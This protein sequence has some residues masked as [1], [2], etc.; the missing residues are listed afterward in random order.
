MAV[1]KKKRPSPYE[2]L[3]VMS[4]ATD[5]EIRAAYRNRAKVL[6]PDAG[7]GADEFAFL[8]ECLALLLDPE[9]R[10]RFDATGI[11][12]EIDPKIAQKR[13]VALGVL[14]GILTQILE[15]GG[16]TQNV[17]A[18]AERE[19]RNKQGELSRAAN[20]AHARADRLRGWAI[21]MRAKPG[22]QNTLAAI[23]EGQAGAIEAT[24]STIQTDLD[25]TDMM[26]DIL[27]EHEWDPVEMTILSQYR[28]STN[29]T[30]SAIG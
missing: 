20:A 14:C 29:A 13:N 23:L 27:A 21:R 2:F 16:E 19:L 6:H 15:R 11:W 28:T 12:E 26:L 3:R 9:R 17:I 10:A 1:E 5:K 24:V 30:T 7:G 8:G 4:D 18:I 25:I 22:K